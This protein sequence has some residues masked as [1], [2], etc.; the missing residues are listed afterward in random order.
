MSAPSR[1]SRRLAA[2]ASAPSPSTPPPPR[3][4]DLPTDLLARISDCFNA[5]RWHLRAA[6]TAR[7]EKCEGSGG[8][9]VLLGTKVGEGSFSHLGRVCGHGRVCSTSRLAVK[10]VCMYVGR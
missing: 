2:A 9:T 4:L 6:F 1:R 7:S 3:L 5:A 8:G 10:R